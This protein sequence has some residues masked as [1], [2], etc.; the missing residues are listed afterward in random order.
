MLQKRCKLVN[1]RVVCPRPGWRWG[2]HSGAP[3]AESGV[4]AVQVLLV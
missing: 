2:D 3:D 1:G 4:P